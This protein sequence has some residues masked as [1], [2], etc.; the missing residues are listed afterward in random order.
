MRGYITLPDTYSC[1]VC[2][3]CGARPVIAIAEEGEYIVKCPNDASHYQTHPGLIDIDDWN[4][5][6][7][8]PVN[9]QIDVSPNALQDHFFHLNGTIVRLNAD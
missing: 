4:Q 1:A 6:N 9:N 3:Y 5:H 8:T 7:S 2:K